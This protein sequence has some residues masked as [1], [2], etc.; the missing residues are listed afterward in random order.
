MADSYRAGDPGQPRLHRTRSVE[1]YLGQARTGQQGQPRARLRPTRAPRGAG[2]A[3]SP[4]ASR[5]RLWSARSRS[6]PSKAFTTRSLTRCTSTGTQACFYAEG[7]AARWRDSG[8]NSATASRCRHGH[9]T[10]DG[11][12]GRVPNAYI[13]VRES[14]LL[15]WTPLLHHRLTHSHNLLI[16][17][18][19]GALVLSLMNIRQSYKSSKCTN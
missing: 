17:A 7:A 6:W 4:S 18:K 19:A 12:A 14:H 13:Y 3:S 15:A 5:T 2:P 11:S 8:S 10:A 16:T 1:A 9:S